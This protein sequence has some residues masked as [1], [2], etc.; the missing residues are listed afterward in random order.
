MFA[1]LYSWVLLEHSPV[2]GKLKLSA[3]AAGMLELGYKK[4]AAGA[5]DIVVV[6][7]DPSLPHL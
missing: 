4:R 6:A 1:P 3:Q 2:A 5:A 7:R